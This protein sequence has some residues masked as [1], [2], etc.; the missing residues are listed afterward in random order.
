[1]ANAGP[2]RFHR[3]DAIP[4]GVRLVLL[5]EQ[6]RVRHVDLTPGGGLRVIAELGIAIQK[7]LANAMHTDRGVVVQPVRQVFSGEDET[8]DE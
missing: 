2:L 1:M 3:A 5:T 7:T 6:G 8:G 4:G